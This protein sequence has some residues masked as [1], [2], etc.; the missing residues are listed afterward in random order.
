MGFL[1]TAGVITLLAMLPLGIRARYR[2]GG[3]CVMLLAGPV[4][5][6]L[7]P[8]TRKDKKTKKIR[9]K[10]AAKGAAGGAAQKNEKAGG[11]VRDFR[12]VV[13]TVLE[14]LGQLRK[15]ICL[16]NL[17]LNLV[18]AAEDPCDLAVN[19]GRAWA[20]VG[21]LMPRLERLFVIKKRSV[22]VQCDF[23]ATDSLIYAGLDI[24]ITL[25]RLVLLLVRYGLKALHQYVTIKNTGKGGVKL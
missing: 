20:A 10:S 6:M 9:Q 11:S 24:T 14:F 4:R 5:I 3:A 25:G 2:A 22:E 17:E 13:Q 7:Y 19:Y 16:D 18:M 8:R 15:K 23:T 1:I 21:N 12:P